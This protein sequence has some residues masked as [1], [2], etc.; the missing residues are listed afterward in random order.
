MNF[1]DFFFEVD[2]I[3][4]KTL[5]LMPWI[6][7]SSEIKSITESFGSSQLPVKNNN[8]S[9]PDQGNVGHHTKNVTG[10]GADLFIKYIFRLILCG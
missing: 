8:Y 9:F 5:N 10:K 7:Q 1:Q 4:S 6:S 2:F 3:G